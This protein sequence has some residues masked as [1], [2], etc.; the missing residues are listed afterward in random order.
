MH[1]PGNDH[2]IY[3]LR[4]DPGIL[5]MSYREMI[6]CIVQHIMI[7]GEIYHYSEKEE[8]IQEITTRLLER[9]ERVRKNYT[10][11]AKLKTYMA[12]VIRNLCHEICREDLT[13]SNPGKNIILNN[14]EGNE[15]K[16]F[17]KRFTFL[18]LKENILVSRKY[19]TAKRTVF[20]SEF[21][22]L[23]IILQTYGSQ[24]AKLEICLKSYFKIEVSQEDI[25]NYFFQN[26]N[27]VEEQVYFLYFDK[28]NTKPEE[29]RKQD[30]F[31]LLTKFFNNTEKHKNSDDAIRK[32]IEVKTHEIIRLLNGNPPNANYNK[33]NLNVFLE[34]F[35]LWKSGK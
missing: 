10:G 15:N 11:R 26:P 23:D 12:A 31:K 33:S 35:Y 9:I 3:L 18:P 7:E 5:I 32:Y 34:L 29:F 30:V 17:R 1:S 20:R 22:R 2:E 21:E 16:R 4:T 24:K 6:A 27:S 25:K 28:L 13:Q 14:T 8:K 19:E